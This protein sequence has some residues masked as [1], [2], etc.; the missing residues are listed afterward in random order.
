MIGIINMNTN[1]INCFLK[2]FKKLKKKYIIINSFDDY[3]ENIDKLLIPG[4]GNY[5]SCINFIKEQKIDKVIY[6]H[7][8][9]NKKIMGICIGMQILTSIGEEGGLTNGLDILKNTKT[10]KM[11]TDKILPNIGWHNIDIINDN[12][13]IYK[14][15][16]K[17]A[18][19]YFVHSYI[20][21]TENKDM[22]SAFS[23]YG[24]TIFPAI[25]KYDNIF[26]TQFHPEKSGPNGIKLIENFL[27]L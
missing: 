23:N 13:P 1:N 10:I 14:N 11:E 3:N 9:N 4:I 12:D 18:D 15:I 7:L 6:T 17:N 5:A 22:I 21:E 20:I 25:I 16:N 2:I 27:N 26:T 24:N 19:F 8:D